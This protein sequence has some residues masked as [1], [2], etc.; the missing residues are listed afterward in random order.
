MPASASRAG[1]LELRQGEVLVGIDQID[2]VVRHGRCASGPA[3]DV[4]M[5]MPR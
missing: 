5:S 4:P 3:F 2:Q 1:R